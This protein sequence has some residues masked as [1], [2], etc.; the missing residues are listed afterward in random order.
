MTGCVES[1]SFQEK[2]ALSF[3]ITGPFLRSTGNS[4]DLRKDFPY[5][6]YDRFDFDVPVGTTGDNFDRYLVRMEEMRQSLR[7]IEQALDSMPDGPT[8]VDSDGEIIDSDLMADL[9]KFGKTRG[10]LNNEGTD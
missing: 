6:I 8:N 9:G 1:A 3:G 2:D 7:I 5:S 10:L 4:F